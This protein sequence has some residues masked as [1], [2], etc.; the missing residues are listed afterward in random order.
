[1]GGGPYKYEGLSM[2]QAHKGMG[3][4]DAEFDALLPHLRIAMLNNGVKAPEV[5]AVMEMVPAVRGE[6]VDAR[7]APVAGAPAAPPATLWD[8]LG[9]QAGVTRIVDDFVDTALK[10]PKVNFTRNGR[11]PMNPQK[12]A[13]LKEQLVRA[14]SSAGGGP[15]K[16][17]G[18]TM[19]QAHAGMGITDAEFDALLVDLRIAMTKHRVGVIDAAIIQ[20]AAE[21][22]RKDIVTG[23]AGAMPA[24]AAGGGAGAKGNADTNQAPAK[25]D[26]EQRPAAAGSSSFTLWLIGRLMG[27]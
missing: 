3:I 9:G 17:E 26:A 23:N 10:D 15:L 13:R 12:V 2:K 22:Y 18:P 11:Y 20:K 27:G 25:S 19:R 1:V 5:I 8:R 7:P 16:Y 21:S 14:A 6:I 24:P 4:T